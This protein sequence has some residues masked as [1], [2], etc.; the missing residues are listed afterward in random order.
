MPDSSN[1]V[2]AMPSFDPG[3]RR[4]ITIAAGAN[5]SEIVS[6]SL[7]G[8]DPEDYSRCRVTLVSSSGICVIERSMWH[9]VKPK[10]GIRVVI[11]VVPGKSSLRSVLA[12]VVSIA[13]IALGSW[14]AGSIMHYAV[15]STGYN[16][17]SAAVGIAVPSCGRLQVNPF[18]AGT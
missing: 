2:I 18:C 16:L 4:E 15:G 1:S 9:C 5:I 6:L 14:F 11:R 13:A 10:P 7:P 8:M 12:V 3:D 17:V